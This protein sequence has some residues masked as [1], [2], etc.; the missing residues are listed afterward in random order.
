LAKRQI[1]AS[2]WYGRN[3]GRIDAALS[4]GNRGLPGGS[5]L[6]KLLT[7]HRS[8]R[9]IHGL[10]ALAIRQILA[11]ANARKRMTGRCPNQ[12]CGQITGTNETWS[13]IN[14]SLNLGSRGLSGGFRVAR[15]WLNS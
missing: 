5:S 7:D 13:G 11:W 8:V 1:R 12:Y 6:A 2:K 14:H 15:H 4:R 10:A 3:V 9:N